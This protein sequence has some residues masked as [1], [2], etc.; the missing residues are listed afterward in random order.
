MKGWFKLTARGTSE[1]RFVLEMSRAL[2]TE[3]ITRMIMMLINQNK[4]NKIKVDIKSA[5]LNFDFN[6]AFAK[7]L[8]IGVFEKRISPFGASIIRPQGFRT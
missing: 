2:N 4:P 3:I 5:K 6:S 7:S 1:F 8:P